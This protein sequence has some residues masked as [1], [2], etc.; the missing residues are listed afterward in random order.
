M[1]KKNPE[2]ASGLKTQLDTKK[3]ASPD[4]K[5]KVPTEKPLLTKSKAQNKSLKTASSNKN[6]T[7]KLRFYQQELQNILKLEEEGKAIKF[8][9]GQDF[10]CVENC[11]YPAL[12]E[13]YC[14]I[15]FFAFYPIITKK[16]EFIDKKLL[17]KSFSALLKKYS[18]ELMDKMLKDLSSEKNFHS[19]LQRINLEGPEEDQKN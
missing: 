5:S 6:P 15:H 9:N 2:K 16:K 7:A 12:L 10:C 17:Q 19:S 14:R 13:G 8:L 4:K 3:S 1:P 18:I 11:D